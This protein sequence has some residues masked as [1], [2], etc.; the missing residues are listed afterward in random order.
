MSWILVLI[1]V[2]NTSFHTVA[3]IDRFNTMGDCFQARQE[4][5]KEIGR[6]IINYQTI[7]VAYD[8]NRLFKYGKPQSK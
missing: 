5:V 7:C 8:K 1:T 4:L 6:P 2:S 3:E